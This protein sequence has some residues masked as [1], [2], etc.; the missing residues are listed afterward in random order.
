M[1]RKKDIIYSSGIGVCVVA[2]IV[3]LAV[4]KKSPVQYYQLIS[5]Y[6]SKKISYIPVQ[7]HE[8][9][10]RYLISVEVAEKKQKMKGLP[11]KELQELEYVL[12]MQKAGKIQKNE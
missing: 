11:Q 4:N 12:K 5:I 2:D 3:N 6:D 8:V 10:L 1:F 7:E 9:E